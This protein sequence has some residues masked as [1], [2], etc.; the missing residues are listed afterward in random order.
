MKVNPLV[1]KQKQS[2][3]L[4]TARLNIWEGSV[5][6]SKTICSLLK[7]MRFVRTAPDGPLL[8]TGKTERTLKRNIIDPL[9]EMLGEKRCKHV[10]GAG[11]LHL[12]GRTIYTAGAHDEGSVD[13]IRGLSLVGAY[14]DE[15]STM[16]ESFFRMLTTRL[17][18]PGAQFF[19]SSNPDGPQHWLKTDFLDRAR[20]HLDIDGQL[21]HSDDPDALNL[22]RFSFQLRDNP[23][24]TDEYIDAVSSEHTGLYYR[25]LILGEWC[26]AEGVVYESWDPA[27]HVVDQ[28]PPIAQWL[29]IALDYGTTNPFHALAIGLGTDGRLYVGHEW[30]WDSK[31]MRGSLTDAEY[32][33][34]VRAWVNGLGIAPSYWIVDPSAKSYRVQMHRDGVTSTLADNEVVD[35]IRDVA[36][37]FATGRLLVHAGCKWLIK[38]IPGYAWDPDASEK[39]EDKPIK[40]ND[41]G[42][43]ALRYGIRTTRNIWSSLLAPPQAK[44]AA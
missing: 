33:E 12:L 26:L 6:S 16:P 39:G 27:R 42:V 4:A 1:G 20:L 41:H 3:Q 36:S 44:E 25:R 21:Q 15:L 17:S 22:N 11:E 38:E 13:K 29:C 34:R 7:W 10:V 5:R 18:I 30:R 23:N 40:L 19:G 32:S 14:G 37:L 43:D 9:T 2:V 31:R 24:L 35:G 8:M 28:L